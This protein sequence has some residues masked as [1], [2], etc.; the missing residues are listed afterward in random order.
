MGSVCRDG[1]R[2]QGDPIVVRLGNVSRVCIESVRCGRQIG[3]DGERVC[4]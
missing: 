2:L 3:K 1:G 4:Q